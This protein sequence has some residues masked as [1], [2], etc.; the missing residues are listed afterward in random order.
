MN[1]PNFIYTFVALWF[2]FSILIIR[3]LIKNSTNELSKI[4]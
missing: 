4:R 1:Y 2:I 3:M